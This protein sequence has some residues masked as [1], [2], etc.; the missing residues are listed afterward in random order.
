MKL[1][2]D[3][4]VIESIIPNPSSLPYILKDEIV[5]FFINFKGHLDK[6][7]KIAF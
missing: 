3:K 6:K 1:S 7:T 2:Y 4:N 5:N